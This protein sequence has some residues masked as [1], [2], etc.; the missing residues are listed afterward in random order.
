MDELLSWGTRSTRP[1]CYDMLFEPVKIG[2]VTARNRFYTCCFATARAIA[3]RRHS[4]MPATLA[5]RNAMGR[6]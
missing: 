1:A 4:P 5:P 6:P 3:I 2:P